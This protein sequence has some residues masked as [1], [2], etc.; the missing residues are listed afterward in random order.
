MIAVQVKDH[1]AEVFREIEHLFTL[2]LD[3]AAE[4]GREVL[5]ENLSAGSSQRTGEW[6]QGQPRRSSKAGE[7]PQEQ[8][9]NLRSMAAVEHVSATQVDFGLYPGSV[10]DAEQAMALEV[11]APRNNLAARAPVYRTYLDPQTHRR[12]MDAVERVL[13]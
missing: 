9:G 1:T 8:T 4:E 10:A 11:G 7:F 12:M 6:Y 3:A 5:E 13:G 2:A